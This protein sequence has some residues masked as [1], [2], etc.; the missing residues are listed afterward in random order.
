MPEAIAAA[1][2]KGLALKGTAA[3]IAK[4]VIEIAVIAG[5]SAV[6]Q[7]NSK[8]KDQGGLI[9]LELNPSAPRRLVIGKRALGGSL[10]DWYVSGADNTKLYLPIYLSEGPCGTI[11]KVFAGGREVF[12]TPLV[13]GVRTVI[14]N[15]RSGGDRLWLTYYDGRVGQTADPTLVA[16]GQGWTA[17]N[18]LT[19]C[20]WVLAEMQWDSDNM[21]SPAQLTFEFEGAKLYDRRKDSTAG[22]SGLHRLDNPSTWELSPG[23]EG[24]NPA[25]ALDHYQ[26][27]RYWNGV[28]VFGI[29]TPMARV[30][31]DAFAA[32]ANVCDEAVALKAGG[33]Q[34]RYRV[35]GIAFADEQHD[36]II[37][38][39]CIAMAAEPADFGGRVGVV[40]IEAKTP[41][42]TIDDDDLIDEASEVFEPKRSWGEL[43]GAVE[44]KYQEPAQLY[45]PIPYKEATDPAWSTEDGG[46]PK[47]IS[48]NLEYETNSERA[49]RLALLKA[50]YERRQATLVGTYPFW[51]IELKRGNWFLRTGRAGSRFG[52]AG[53]L[54]EVMDRILDPKTMRV[55]IVSKEVDPDDSAWNESVAGD[56]PPA[57]TAGTATVAAIPVPAITVQAITIAGTASNL[58]ALKITFT[59]PTDP[60]V[61]WFYVEVENT[62]G[63]TPKTSKQIAIPSDTNTLIFQDGIVDGDQY[64]VSAK[65]LSDT[66][67]SDWSVAALIFSSGT[68]AVGTAASV[69]WSGVTGTGKP[70]DNATV[71]GA[72]GINVRETS[73]GVIA[74][75]NAFK[76]VLGTSAAITGQGAFATVNTA[77]YGSGLLTGFG[78][79]AALAFTTLGTNLRRADATTIVTDALAITSLGSAASIAGQGGLA[80]LNFT[81]LGSNVRLADAVTIATNA[82]LLT[83]LGTAAAITGQGAFATVSSAAYGSALL[84]G[85]GSLAP[86]AFTSLGLNVRRADGVTSLTDALAVTSLGTAAAITGQGTGATASNLAGLNATD[87]A[88]LNSALAGIRR[89]GDVNDFSNDGLHWTTTFG[90]TPDTV[91]DPVADGYFNVAD[92]GR[93]IRL[94]ATA[95]LTKKS[96]F[97]PVEG[98]RY[99]QVVRL[100]AHTNPS[101]G[102]MTAAL[103]NINGLDVNYFHGAGVASSTLTP[104]NAIFQKANFVVADGWITLA[105]VWVAGPPST[106]NAYWR[107]RVDITQTGAGGKVEVV[108][109]DDF[110]VTDIPVGRSLSDLFRADGSTPLSDAT[111]ITSVGTA[112]AITG[113]GA[114]AT[115]SSA[116]Y[117]SGLLTGFGALA[118]LAFTT[119]G[120]NVRRADATTVVTDAL[121]I[122]SLGSAASIAGQGAFATLNSAAYGSA[123]LTGFGSL[124]PLSSITGLTAGAVTGQGALATLSQV[125]LGASGRVYRDDGATRLTDALAVTS[126]GSAASIAGQGAFAT[127][128]SAAYGSGLLTGFGSLAALS[129]IASLT[130]GAITGQGWGATASE[131]QARAS[132]PTGLL[133]NSNFEMPF[134]GASVP[135]LWSEWSFGSTSTFVTK[136]IGDGKCVQLVGVAAQETGFSQDVVI[137]AS[138]D[139]LVSATVR[140]NSGT[141]VGAGVYITFFNASNVATGD[142]YLRFATDPNTGGVTSST[143]D[144]VQR[145]EKVFSAPAGTTYVRV[146]CMAHW[147]GHG[148][149]ADANSISFYSCDVEPMSL[150]RQLRADVTSGN[151]AAAFSGQGALATQNSLA[152]GGGFLTGFAA[153]AALSFVQLSSNVRLA[154]GTTIATNATLVT[155]LGTAAAISGQGALATK[156]VAGAADISVANLGAISATIGLLRTATTGARMELESNQGRV[157]DASNV[158][159]VRWGVW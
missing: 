91:A 48:H 122:T 33:T 27:G 24:A 7:N 70:E 84:T 25:V 44:G 69:P 55:S 37:K 74:L 76:T 152:Y 118:P 149:I 64:A 47:R 38:K 108:S 56:P 34:K 123:L 5:A 73:G 86:L 50:K 142:G 12:S 112:A 114:F 99:L 23:G 9:N 119:L 82:L 32:Q 18:K 126:L 107:F 54:F 102:A 45:Q 46:E 75:L 158:L 133:K 147:T 65:F 42:L 85:F 83:S 77:A 78:A 41:V 98:R 72:F 121:A 150:V 116:A 143:H 111:V 130:A 11:T 49:E 115:L 100:R 13:H 71:G 93:V 80:T 59:P 39:L 136:P 81:T 154:D 128:S 156:N 151:T 4:V 155:S 35:N 113:Q 129:S 17:N 145:F 157:Y 20:A 124:A 87:N 125:N 104:P 61:K 120:T 36:D 51:T 2:I 53:K 131:D 146:Y 105:R 26:L 52:E 57:P 110:D 15:F 92:V 29:G 8:Q 148:S 132:R 106:Y 10:V 14:P 43:V 22:G 97:K 127:L 28:K 94:S 58:P 153:L 16:L 67:Q 117:G 79:L 88:N 159:R 31:Y 141:F 1:V 140:R 6:V 19:G 62:D 3:F 60:R 103:S 89:I 96:V 30:P 135:P 137:G 40:G 66:R 109:F 139:Y 21:R 138:Q 63:T 144:G 68:Y 101:S 95:Y 134:I 90:G